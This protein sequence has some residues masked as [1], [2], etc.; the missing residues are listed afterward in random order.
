M[1]GPARGVDVA[2]VGPDDGV[3]ATI[4][5]R[6][7]AENRS[8]PAILV[9]RPS[10]A[11]PRSARPDLAEAESLLRG[12]VA[13]NGT[14]R[15]SRVILLSSTR[16]HPPD[17]HNPG[18]LPESHRPRHPHPVSRAW[19]DLEFL[20][21]SLLGE[22]GIELL[23][24]RPAPVLAPDLTPEG[25]DPFS[26]LLAGR[27]AAVPA[28]YDPALQLL[29]PEDLA[30]A[31]ACAVES[32]QGHR[33]PY[34]VVPAGAVPV[35]G[36]L[37]LAGARRWPVPAGP[38]GQGESLRDWLRHSWTASGRAIERDLG[39]VPR[40]TSARAVLNAFGT[41]TREASPEYDA[42]GQDLHY[43]RAY[44]RTLFRFLHDVYWRVEHE[45]LENVPREGRAVLTGVHRGLMPWDGVMALHLLGR[46]LG[47]HPRFLIHPCLVKLPFLTNYMTKL[48]GMLACQE[49]AD[50]VLGRG[51]IL[52]MYPEGIQ[53]AFTRYRDAYHIGKLG[54]DE[55]V[56]M[57]LRNRAPIVP[58]VTVGS[59]EIYPILA[60]LDWGWWKRR[61]EWPC[62][63]VGPNFP[64][65]G[66]PLPSK[67]HTRFLAPL[68][69]Q[70]LYPP[71]AAEDP[72][73][74]RTISAEVRH[75]MEEAIGEM[76][77]RRKSIFFGSVFPTRGP[78]EPGLVRVEGE[79]P[80][81]RMHAAD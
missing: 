55:F 21:G 24:L 79:S 40:H 74:V 57:A 28:G 72:N 11:G 81:R 58:F 33:G 42:Y 39:F 78:G 4:A 54:R 63:P 8:V 80:E 52:G 32:G 76:L 49:N 31:V 71:E 29:D 25:A 18:Y 65:P 14:A 67:W 45:G 9:Y 17:H 53:G 43:I 61:S 3:T 59:A 15:P 70:D 36:M 16:V 27:S 26:W 68:P 23:I 41:A 2:V 13:Q 34:H 50:W 5:R 20:A 44:G 73:V 12:C 60:R 7:R 77:A 47:R 1:N 48:G 35:R 19:R 10:F 6:L 75:R 64:L 56:R 66:L 69:V 51:E 22:A 62:F 38:T 46:E 37:R 30:A